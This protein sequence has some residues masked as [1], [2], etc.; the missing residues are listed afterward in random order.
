MM[1]GQQ[2]IKFM[3][4][5]RF[6]LAAL[7]GDKLNDL[8]TVHHNIAGQQDQQDALFAFSLLRLLF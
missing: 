5:Y 7:D 8:L 4:L 6:R 1:H 2:N 3:K